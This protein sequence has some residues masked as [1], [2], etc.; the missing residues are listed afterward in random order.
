MKTREVMPLMQ[1]L[2][3][4]SDPRSTRQVRHD[5]AELLTVAVCAVLCSA[6]EF[7][8]I[9]AWAKERIDWLRGFLVLE[10]GIPSHDTFGRVFAALDPGEFEAAFRRWVGQLIPALD[11]DTVVAIDGKTSRRSTTKAQAKPLHM[12]SAFAAD[13]GLVLGQ[14]ATAEK[15]NEITAIPELL[16]TLALEGCVVTIDAMGAQ[17]SIARTI[18][19]RGADYVLCVKDNHPKLVESFLLA[20][21]GVGG[22]LAPTSTSETADDGHG[23]SEVRRCWAFNA[24]ERLYKAE[25]WADLK[26]FAIIERERTVAGKRSCERRYYISSLPADA[27]RIAHAVRSHW[28]VENRLHW[29]LDVQFNED[30]STVRTGFAANNFAIVRHIV[31]NLLRMNTSRKGSIKTKRMLAATSDRFRAELL[32][33]MT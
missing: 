20:Q 30:Q 7:S 2:V 17:A 19:N 8:E 28:E 4:I 1:V 26:S 25:Q 32:G 11:S 13:I 31:M 29:C 9:E 18:R 10:N 14:T 5:L 22:K 15:S 16:A 33:V 24:V 21:A 12:V 3:S 6:D 23:R 27:R